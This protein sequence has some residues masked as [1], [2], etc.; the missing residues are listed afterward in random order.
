MRF[1]P[2]WVLL[3]RVC[4]LKLIQVLP[5][6]NFNVNGEIYGFWMFTHVTDATRGNLAIGNGILTSVNCWY[7]FGMKFVPCCI[8][9][10]R[11]CLL[12][13]IQVL[14]DTHFIAH[15]GIYG[16]WMLMD[17]TDAFQGNLT[18]GNGILTSVNFWYLFEIRFMPWWILLNRVCLLKL[19]QVLTDTN[20]NVNREIYGL[21]MLTHV[22][23]ASQGNMTVGNGIFKSVKFWYLDLWNWIYTLL[24]TAEEC[25]HFLRHFDHY[26]HETWHDGVLWQDPSKHTTFS[27]LQP[28]SPP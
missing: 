10:N 8:L 16:F 12:K 25:S 28:R 6:R 24:E 17:A 14:T 13:L 1:M 11:L 4:L 27:D 2:Y 21:W 15:R 9:L 5:K 19:I 7:L 3:N 26:S 23:D 20:F 22:Y 18:I